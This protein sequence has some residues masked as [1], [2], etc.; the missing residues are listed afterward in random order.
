MIELLL[1]HVVVVAL[2]TGAASALC[3]R[4]AL[5]LRRQLSGLGDR[6][7]LLLA[8]SLLVCGGA[9]P[10]A[11]AASVSPADGG[12]SVGGSGVQP[13]GDF[14]AVGVA[15]LRGFVHGLCTRSVHTV[16]EASSTVPAGRE[17]PPLTGVLR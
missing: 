13:V 1:S 17:S 15:G 14:G 6:E 10:A 4:A 3:V 9:L 12:R 11:H 8:S 7:R 16:P 2:F 5:R